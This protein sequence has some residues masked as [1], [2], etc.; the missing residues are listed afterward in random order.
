M[1]LFSRRTSAVKPATPLLRAMLWLKDIDRTARAEPTFGKA[2]EE[3]SIDTNPLRSAIKWRHE[4]TRLS[5]TEMEDAFESVYKVAEQL[6]DI[7]DKL[8]V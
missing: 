7:I 5:E 6:S 1:A 4:K 2:A 3:F 8:K